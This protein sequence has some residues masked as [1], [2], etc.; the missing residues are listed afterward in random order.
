[1]FSQL[2][3]QSDYPSLSLP[4]F[5][6]LSVNKCIEAHIAVSRRLLYDNFLADRRPWVISFSGGKDSTLLLQLV[7]ELLLELDSR[8]LKPVHVIASDTKV[9]APNVEKYLKENLT[10][11][12]DHARKSSLDL[13]VH[14]VQPDIDQ[15]FWGNLIGKGYPPPTRWF[16]WCTTKMK[17]KPVR[18]VVDS[19]VAEYGSVILLLGTRIAESANRSRQMQGRSYSSRGLNPHHDIP[20]AL[21]LQPIS[22][23]TT[24]QV[25]EYL[26]SNNPP[27]WNGS[28]DE[29][30]RL[31]RKA[32][33]G[34][35]PVITDLDTPPCGGNRFGCWVC[36]LIKEDKS[37][38][39]FIT[40][41]EKWMQP[42]Y[43]FRNWLKC[44]R[45]DESLRNKY[46]RNGHEG[47]GPFTS[48]ARLMILENLL[49]TEQEV[50]QQL[51]GDDE[52]LYIQRIWTEEFDVMDSALRLVRKYKRNI[53]MTEKI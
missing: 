19:I 37:M 4:P 51:I 2:E 42:L 50:E 53:N 18:K 14:L 34:E 15:G 7:Y 31:Y 38:K 10:I 11:L 22:Q 17:I 9:E 43:D 30:L 45:E 47:L 26:F 16:R 24:D 41:G 32:N 20:N 29:M 1:M 33:N 44:I 13:T 40:S 23:W 21:V 52:L 8:H 6:A 36:T 5:D 48:D 28:H 3:K 25:W 46:K 27:P 39:G 49:K 35:C 12:A